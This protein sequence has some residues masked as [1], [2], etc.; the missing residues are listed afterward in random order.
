ML[1]IAPVG[2]DSGNG[3]SS[4]TNSPKKRGSSTA[5]THKNVL[6]PTTVSHSLTSLIY[7]CISCNKTFST[8][9]NEPCRSAKQEWSIPNDHLWPHFMTTNICSTGRRRQLPF[10]CEIGSAAPLKTSLRPVF[11]PQI[12]FAT[13][14]ERNR[15]EYRRLLTTD[16]VHTDPYP[17][18]HLKLFVSPRPCVDLFSRA[19][20]LWEWFYIDH[21]FRLITDP[22][23]RGHLLKSDE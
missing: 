3:D 1:A 7:L 22:N 18:T 12:S 2:A 4:Y 5:W 10:F 20:R 23:V 19:D 14:W 11:S 15:Q 8:T 13:S 21:L 17:V 9:K 6:L 16:P